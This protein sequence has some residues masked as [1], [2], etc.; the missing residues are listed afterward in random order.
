MADDS[1]IKIDKLSIGFYRNADQHYHE[2]V[3]NVGLS[4]EKGQTLALV[5]ESGSGKTL[6]ALSI[7]QLQTPAAKISLESRIW[8][9]RQDLLSLPEIAMRKIRGRRIGMIFQEAI[10]A[11]NPVLTI[12]SQI[13]EVLRCHFHWHDHEYYDRVLDLLDEVGLHNPAHWVDAYPHELS[14]GMRQRVMIA[15]ALAGEPDILIADEPTT[16]LDVTLQVQILHLIQRLQE[17]FKMSLLFITHD[18]SIVE[19]IADR[20]VVLEHGKIAEQANKQ[21]FFA[22]P[23][24]QCSKKLLAAIPSLNKRTRPFTVTPA[25]KPLLSVTNLK[26]YFP[27]RKGIF[28]RTVGYIKAVDDISFS[29]HEGRT[30]ALVGESGSGKTTTGRSILELMLP[31]SGEIEFENLDLGKLNSR[32]MHNI[33]KDLQMIFQDPYTAMDPRMLVSDIIMEGLSATGNKFSNSEKE[34]RIA[35]LLSLV[36]LQ[37]EY[38]YRYPHEF[39]GGERQRIG[40]ARALAVE[41]RLIV[42]D[43]ITS[44]LDVSV[45]MQILDLLLKLQKELGLTYLLITHNLGVVAYLADEMAVLHEGKIVEI[46]PVQH[47]LQ[48]PQHPYTKRLIEAA[49]FL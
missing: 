9:E 37:P 5:G 49:H 44:A 18:L 25:T 39:S 15:I 47:I 45:Q 4:L 13:Q 30:F 21:D 42:C 10:T 32:R 22:N 27:I 1:I 23:Q 33:R 34:T 43:E 20:V 16:A 6:T 46:G 24:A 40:I 17:K 38:Q 2:A 3:S 12:G 19:Q 11:L 31:T 36:G 28:K 7:V 14:G 41:P 29:I 26:T 48:S 8:F 35:E